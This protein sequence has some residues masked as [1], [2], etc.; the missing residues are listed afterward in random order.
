MTGIETS[1]RER[2]DDI[3]VTGEVNGAMTALRQTS[4]PAA[5]YP[6]LYE[7]LAAIV[8]SSDDAIISEDLSGI[9]QSWNRGAQQ[10]FGYTPA[11][12]IG[13]PMSMLAAPDCPDDIQKVLDRISRG[14]RVDHYLTRR[15]TKEGRV[16]SISLTVSPIRNAEG[17]IVGAS[18]IAR[19]VTEQLES[20][21]TL[22]AANELLTRLNSDLEQFVYSA[23]HDLQEP[24][25]MISTSAGMIRRKCGDQLG[26]SGDQYLGYIL[27][28]AMRME[29]LLRSLR[30]FL[31]ASASGNDAP[32]VSAT[33]SLCI[34]LVNLTPAIQNSGVLI[35]YEN[36]PWVRMHQFQMEQ[37]FQNLI[38]NAI[39]YRNKQQPKVHI[40]AQPLGAMWQFSVTDN[41]IGIDPQYREHI[42]GIFKRLYSAGDLTG[43]GMGLA[44]CQRIVER[45]GG[46]I[47]VQSSLGEG[48][49]FFFTVPAAGS[50]G[51]S[52]SGFGA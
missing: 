21:R 38:G 51:S 11:E 37:L 42:F 30:D 41:G 23:S 39:H 10:M 7:R 15:L 45:A 25:R 44:I 8:E 49:T 27:N 12:V 40:D 6:E 31:V 22:R 5:D 46:R 47:W 1:V 34:A 26:A 43:T 16:L 13:R 35:T 48:A 29:Q 24:L 20:D 28:G 4:Y 14:E 18:K 2:N 9:I 50:G 33:D 17:E 36:L 19:D 32:D 52:D 3:T